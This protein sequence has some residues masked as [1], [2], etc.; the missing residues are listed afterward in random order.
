MAI[1]TSIRFIIAVLAEA[2][3]TSVSRGRSTTRGW[4]ST[5]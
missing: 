4:R 3:C 5:P 1:A 2:L